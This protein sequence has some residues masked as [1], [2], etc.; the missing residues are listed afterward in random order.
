MNFTVRVPATTANLGPGFDCLGLA[1]DLWN[2]AEFCFEGE[3]IC[4]EIHGEGAE[5][6]SKKPDNLILTAFFRLLHQLGAPKPRGV[7]LRVQNHVPVGSGLGSSASAVVAGLLAARAWSGRDIPA[8]RLLDV[9]VSLEGHADNASAALFG[10]LTVSVNTPQGW[11]VERFEPAPMQMVVVLPQFSLST[12]SARL[13]LPA[14]LEHGDAVF[15]LG[16]TALV[17]EALRRGDLEL[18]GRV[19]DDRLHQPYRLPL[20]PGAQ[21]ALRAAKEAGAA[22]VALS[23]A[24]PSLIAFPYQDPEPVAHSMQTA[25]QKQGVPARAFYLHSTPLGAQILG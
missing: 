4:V 7:R 5:A 24:G 3:G 25:F 1:L 20:I 10:G 13:A 8:E 23:G 21:D 6:L 15:N 9:A 12:R 2:E 11:L 18:L 17:V 22:A 14:L 19:M 16:R